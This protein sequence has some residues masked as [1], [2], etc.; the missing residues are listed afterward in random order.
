MRGVKFILKEIYIG[1]EVYGDDPGA[2]DRA[3]SVVR[4]SKSTGDYDFAPVSVCAGK[5]MRE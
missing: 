1:G 2:H 5:R 4:L 3:H